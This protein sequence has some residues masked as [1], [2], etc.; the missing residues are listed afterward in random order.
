MMGLG[1]PKLSTKFKIV[2]FI[3]CRTNEKKAPKF[4]E[5]RYPRDTITSSFMCD[6][7]MDLDKLQPVAKFEITIF[8]YYRNTKDFPKNWDQ[9][10]WRSSYFLDKLQTAVSYTMYN[11]CGAVTNKTGRFLLKLHFTNRKF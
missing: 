6:F 10:K 5:L 11:L 8:I 7:T 4:W 1:K 9:P 3:H 2:I